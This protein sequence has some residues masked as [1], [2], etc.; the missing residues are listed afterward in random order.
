MIFGKPIFTGHY[1]LIKMTRGIT[2][3]I[4]NHKIVFNTGLL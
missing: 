3:V 4:H 2:F 1:L